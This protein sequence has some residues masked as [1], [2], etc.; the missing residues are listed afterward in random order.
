MLKHILY[1]VTYLYTMYL[2]NYEIIIL[3][4]YLTMY[5]IHDAVGV[6]CPA[7]WLLCALLVCTCISMSV[8][9]IMYT[10]G[11]SFASLH[12]CLQVVLQNW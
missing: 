8:G 6:T 12:L 10:L 11:C 4:I 1:I 9:L 2:F 5:C 7:L 3:C